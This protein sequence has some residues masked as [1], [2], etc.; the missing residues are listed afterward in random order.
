MAIVRRECAC[1]PG[2]AAAPGRHDAAHRGPAE[3]APA[4]SEEPLPPTSYIHFVAS[5][6]RCYSRHYRGL[7]SFPA[8]KEDQATLRK[9]TL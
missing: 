9:T 6:I 1:G 5:T 2:E 3:G 4:H 8:P 7:G